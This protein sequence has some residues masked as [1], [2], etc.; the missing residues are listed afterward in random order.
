M[1][2]LDLGG[3]QAVGMTLKPHLVLLPGLRGSELLHSAEHVLVAA[4]IPTAEHKVRQLRGVTA[5][6][7]R[8][9][10]Q[11]R[12]MWPST[13]GHS[14]SFRMAQRGMCRHSFEHAF[15]ILGCP[16]AH[17]ASATTSRNRA[18]W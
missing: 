16:A 10:S 9:R 13:A 1:V 3:S 6:S 14:R 2:P 18:C 17:P 4:V 15:S 12:E 8:E 11:P 5:C 7:W